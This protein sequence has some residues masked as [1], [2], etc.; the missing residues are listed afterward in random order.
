MVRDRPGRWRRARSAG[1][2]RGPGPGRCWWRR[3]SRARPGRTRPCRAAG[4]T[5][6]SSPPRRRPG[7]CAR[8]RARRAPGAARRAGAP[9]RPR[10]ATGRPRCARPAAR[11]PG[12]R[13]PWWRA[14][15]SSAGRAGSSAH[16]TPSS[17]SAGRAGELLGDGGNHPARAVGLLR[18]QADRAVRQGARAGVGLGE[19]HGSVGARALAQRAHQRPAAVG[20]RLV[21]L[22]GQ[23]GQRHEGRQAHDLRG[24]RCRLAAVGQRDHRPQRL[25]AGTDRRLGRQPRRHLRGPVG[26]P[27]GHVAPHGRQPRVAGAR[28]DRRG[29]LRRSDDGDRAARGLRREPRDGGEPAAGRDGLDHA[30][31][32]VAE[33][34]PGRGIVRRRRWEPT[35]TRDGRGCQ[36][37]LCARSRSR[38]RAVG[39]CHAAAR[40][41]RLHLARRRAHRALRA[42]RAGRCAG[43]ARRR[44]RPAHHAARRGVGPAVVAGAAAVHHVPA[45]RVD[46][47]AGDLREAVAASCSSRSAA[48]AWSTSPRRWRPPTARRR[49]GHPDD[50]ERRRDDARAPPRPRGR[51]GHAARAPA[52]RAQRPG[53][54]RLA[55]RGRPGGLGRQRARP[56][57]RGPADAAGLAR[58]RARRPRGGAPAR[59]R[60]RPRRA[61]PRRA[62]GGLRHRL[63]RLRPA[64]RARPDARALR[65]RVARPRERRDAAPHDRRP[66]PARA[67]G[68]G[69][70]GRRGR[71]G[72][73]DPGAAA[74]PPR[75]RAAAARPRRHRGGAGDVRRR[76][77][78]RGQRPRRHAARRRARP[79]IRALYEAA[80]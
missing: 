61:R 24:R 29:A 45:G 6:R 37:T 51:P 30:R 53:A 78:K 50:P 39:V 41:P 21:A 23:G 14:R 2:R 35:G 15:A 58:A 67:R 31:V 79:E 25:R 65:R 26:E 77:L 27:I 36:P 52:D 70:A 73:G 44:L 10:R 48:G 57:H 55:A 11:R 60:G 68:A 64:P 74:G 63:H 75:G 18:A 72:D 22:Q 32:Q 16:T 28:R 43:P 38:V 40:D 54:E 49:G 1:A 9:G 19:Q 47:V 34:R 46:E 20:F 3:R 62:A 71:R 4:A 76:G 80:F 42:R 17:C 69:R 56:R 8:A 66:A 12:A 13:R 33:G 5:C 59:A 7:R